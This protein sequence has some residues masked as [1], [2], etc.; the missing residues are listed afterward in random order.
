MRVSCWWLRFGRALGIVEDGLR[1]EDPSDRRDRRVSQA[2]AD[3][4]RALAIA[5]KWREP[6]PCG[7]I[8]VRRRKSHATRLLRRDVVNAV[9]R[10]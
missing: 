4:R 9:K 10:S 5:S 7:P 1:L 6:P 2:R 3:V 8:T